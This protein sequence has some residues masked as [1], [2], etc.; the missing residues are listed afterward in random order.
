M[1]CSNQVFR[2]CGD[3]HENLEK[4]I[5][6][7]LAFIGT[8][9]MVKFRIANG[10]ITFTK[11]ECQSDDF[12]YIPIY[13]SAYMMT[14]M[15]E[16]FLKSKEAQPYYENQYK[17]GDGSFYKG[18]EIFVSEDYNIRGDHFSVRPFTTYYSK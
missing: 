9:N 8:E 11:L 17:G 16:T 15:I 12:Q 3:T 4:A 5:E 13:G 6:C 14:T 18:W 1:F 10:C 2:I 7:V